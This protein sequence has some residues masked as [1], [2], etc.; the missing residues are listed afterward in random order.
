MTLCD[1]CGPTSIGSRVFRGGAWSSDGVIVYAISSNGLWR[2]PDT[3]GAPVRVTPAGDYGYPGFL[4]DGEH[5]LYTWFGSDPQP[6]VYVGDL[7]HHEQRPSRRLIDG[8]FVL[9]GYA[10]RDRAKGGYLLALREG[11]LTARSFDPMTATL[12]GEPA[13]IA[14]D[15]PDIGS[16]CG[17]LG[18]V[19]GYAGVQHV[20]IG[21]QITTGVVRP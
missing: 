1:R 19:D 17:I 20:D 14:Q 11:V 6:G 13:V 2:I 8:A 18:V 4:P 16:A 7:R 3:G 21:R 15:V 10:P 12:S 9:S 5:V